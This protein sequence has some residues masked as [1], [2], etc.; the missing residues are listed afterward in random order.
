[1]FDYK[2]AIVQANFCLLCVRATFVLE[3]R[4]EGNLAMDALSFHNLKLNKIMKAIASKYLYLH[5]HGLLQLK[6]NSCY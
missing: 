5:T 2:C 4:K 3:A 6:T 1:M